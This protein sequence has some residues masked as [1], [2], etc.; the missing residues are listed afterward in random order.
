MDEI[1]R[2]HST[3]HVHKTH[4]EPIVNEHPVG[5]R[6]SVA[7]KQTHLFRVLKEVEGGIHTG[8]GETISV[9]S[10]VPVGSVLVGRVG[11]I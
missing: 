1:R 8:Y 11:G 10:T 6:L 3:V 2:E 4:E 7:D 5:D 9:P